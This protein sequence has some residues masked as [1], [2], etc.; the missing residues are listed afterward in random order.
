MHYMK[1]ALNKKKEIL[2]VT[3]IIMLAT[4]GII[5]L[6]HSGFFVSDDGEWMIIRF[7]AFHQALVHGQFPVRLLPRLNF[8]YGYPVTDFLYPGFLYF[9]EPIHLAK[10]GFITTIK[11]IAGLSLISS[12]IFTYFW[13]RS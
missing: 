5:P 7:T 9:A 11:L 13:L 6:L 3:F 8:E 4:P 1:M 12:V 2:L 10:I